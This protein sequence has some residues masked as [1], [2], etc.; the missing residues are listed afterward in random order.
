MGQ[1]AC[2]GDGVKIRLLLVDD[3]VMPGRPT[4]PRPRVL[5]KGSQRAFDIFQRTMSMAAPK[6]HRIITQN[7]NPDDNGFRTGFG[8]LTARAKALRTL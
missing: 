7:A 1:P 4:Q 2:K 5:F 8:D 3:R 6:G